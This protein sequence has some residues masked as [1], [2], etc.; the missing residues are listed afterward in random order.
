MDEKSRLAVKSI[1]EMKASDALDNDSYCKCM[2]E[3]SYNFFKDGDV[4]SCIQMIGKCSPE[5]FKS[6][7]LQHMQEDEV[8]KDTVI[9]LAFKFVQMGLVEAGLDV[10]WTTNKWGSA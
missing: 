9:Y 10:P 6:K 3:L 1:D 4:D 7:Q 5:Y 8:Y 2:V